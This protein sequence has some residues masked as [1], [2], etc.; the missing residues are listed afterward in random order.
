MTPSEHAVRPQGALHC[1]LCHGRI[2]RRRALASWFVFAH[3]LLSLAGLWL[4]YAFFIPAVARRFDDVGLALPTITE[5]VFAVARF[6]G[7]ER[8]LAAGAVV[9]VG[10]AQ[11][12]AK[13]RSWRRTSALLSALIV[14]TAVVAMLTTFAVL[15]PFVHLTT[16]L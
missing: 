11:L 5:V 15:L 16:R 13:G 6:A 4:A 10:V 3:W 7:S 9:L 12:F 2:P 14:A 8:G 1:V